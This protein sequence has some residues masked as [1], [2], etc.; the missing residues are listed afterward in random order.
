MGRAANPARATRRGTALIVPAGCIL[1][2]LILDI[3]VQAGLL[4]DE[5]DEG[6]GCNVT[7]VEPGHRR[8]KARQV[9]VIEPSR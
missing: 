4:E 6:R 8:P 7:K 3:G 5:L 2:G 1:F 9:C